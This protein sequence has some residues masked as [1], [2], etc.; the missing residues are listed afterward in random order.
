MR[1]ISAWASRASV[2]STLNVRVC[3]QVPEEKLL[4]VAVEFIN[5]ADVVA[6]VVHIAED[7]SAWSRPLDVLAQVPRRQPTY[8]TVG[9]HLPVHRSEALFRGEDT[10]D[11]RDE[12]AP[13]KFLVHQLPIRVDQPGQVADHPD[14]VVLA[15][16]DAEETA[17]PGKR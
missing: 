1:L 9:L 4:A 17:R 12:V 3:L 15:V 7:D 2:N 8:A 14:L 11:G 5:V 10:F 16:P 13:L 6:V